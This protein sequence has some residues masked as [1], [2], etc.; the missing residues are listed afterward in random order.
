[1]KLQVATT[2]L[3]QLG[4]NKFIA[5]T[6]AKNLSGDEA[7]LN[8]KI[9]RNKSKATHVR[10]NYNQGQDLYQ[11]RFIQFNSKSCELVDLKVLEGVY[12]DM[13]QEIF[14]DFTGLATSL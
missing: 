9:G 5:M 7:G 4:G 14:T 12:A 2:I 8:F 1:M 3:Q 11:V 10:I 13:L 6:G